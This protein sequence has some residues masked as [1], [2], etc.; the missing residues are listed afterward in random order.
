MNWESC[1]EPKNSLMAA[2]TGRAL[3]RLAAVTVAASQMVIRSL[4]IRSI[5]ISP[6]RNWFWRSSPTAR[7][8]RL[9]RWSMSSD[10]PWPLLSEISL[11]TMET[12]S[13]LSSTRRSLSR[14]RSRASSSGMPRFLS[15]LKRPT[16]LR[17][18]RRGLKKSELSRLRAF[19]TVGGSP[20]R[21]LR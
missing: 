21:I 1:E 20:G 4:M 10:S 7:T 11:R 3:I 16:L 15:S 17:S 18:K 13:W 2:T 14:A 12:K 8:R 9:P 6:I 5:R 19:S